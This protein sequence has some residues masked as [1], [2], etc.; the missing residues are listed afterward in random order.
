[1]R[2]EFLKLHPLVALLW[3][4]CRSTGSAFGFHLSPSQPAQQPVVF[5]RVREASDL[6]DSIALG[7]KDAQLRV[8]RPAYYFHHMRKA[9]GSTLRE[10][11][12]CFCGNERYFQVCGEEASRAR[13]EECGR[14]H[15]GCSLPQHRF[16]E[17]FGTESN[18]GPTVINLREPVARAESLMH[19]N[20]IDLNNTC[21]EGKGD[22]FH[23]PERDCNDRSANGELWRTWGECFTMPGNETPNIPMWNCWR[24]QY[25]KS[26]VGT[27]RNVLTWDWPP[28]RQWLYVDEQDLEVAKQRLASFSGVLISEWFG[29]PIL[30]EY[31]SKHVF[32]LNKTLPFPH[33]N[34]GRKGGGHGSSG[35][36]AKKQRDWV[37]SENTYD[38]ELYEFAKELAL[39]RLIDAGYLVSMSELDAAR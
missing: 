15:E 34:D 29:H 7:D 28:I 9:G 24:N 14:T 10:W 23:V 21:A 30:A 13:V 17:I 32:H 26:L 35:T 36:F 22:G 3:A 27:D 12:Q 5:G 37:S 18:I 31:L 2:R 1:M 6:T 4:T 8:A 33:S 16:D 38:I 39:K 20:L 11:L 25:V 19:M